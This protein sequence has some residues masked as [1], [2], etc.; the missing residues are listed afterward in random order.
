[1]VLPAKTIVVRSR[2]GWRQLRAND[3]GF[4]REKHRL[5]RSVSVGLAT[6]EDQRLWFCP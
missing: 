2:F 5:S 6:A 3:H 1:M 4:A